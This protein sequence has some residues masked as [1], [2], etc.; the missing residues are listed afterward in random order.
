M[1]LVLDSTDLRNIY[2]FNEPCPRVDHHG[3]SLTRL[4]AKSRCKMMEA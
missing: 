4:A 3:G 2:G 1:A